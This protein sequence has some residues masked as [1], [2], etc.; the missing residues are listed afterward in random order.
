MFE[1]PLWYG[2]YEGFGTQPIVYLTKPTAIKYFGNEVALGE[3]LTIYIR[4]DI[5]YE[6]IVGGVFERIPVNSSFDFN[7]L[8]SEDDYSRLREMEQK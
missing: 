3:K 7:F 1:I 6:A 4:N 8:M 2:S 5:K